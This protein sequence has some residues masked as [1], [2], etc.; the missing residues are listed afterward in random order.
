[1]WYA[2]RLSSAKRNTHISTQSSDLP[3]KYYIISPLGTTTN[4]TT[5]V[6]KPFNMHNIVNTL[7]TDQYLIMLTE[8]Y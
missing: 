6:L 5:P 2:D 3:S 4:E 8:N 7:K 1:M